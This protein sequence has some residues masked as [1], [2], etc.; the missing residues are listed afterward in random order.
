MK[1]LL[2]T[3]TLFLIVNFSFAQTENFPFGEH[4]RQNDMS[5]PTKGKVSFMSVSIEG[6][7]FTFNYNEKRNLIEMNGSV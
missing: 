1:N 4:K 7:K 2:I 3:S 6:S 5:K